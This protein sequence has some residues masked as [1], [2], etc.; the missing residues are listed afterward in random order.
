[1][2]Y[3]EIKNEPEILSADD[4][5]LREMCLSLKKIDAPANFDFRLKARIAGSR[6]SDFQPRFG[7]AFRYALPALAL[8]FAFVFLAYNSGFFTSENKTVVAEN[9]PAKITEIECREW[10]SKFAAENDDQFF[11]NTLSTLRHIFEKAGLTR[12]DNPAYKIKR[13]GVKPKELKLPEAKQFEELLAIILVAHE[14]DDARN[15]AQVSE[16]RTGIV[17]RNA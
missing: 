8:I 4:Q 2:S 9:S 11:N 5:K 17:R 16:A 13:L 6:K 7:W 3:Q 14:F 1:M 10:A 12:E 15:D